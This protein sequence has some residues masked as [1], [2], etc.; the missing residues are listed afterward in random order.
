MPLRR[1]ATYHLIGEMEKDVD[2]IDIEEGDW[3]FESEAK[4]GNSDEDSDEDDE[5]SADDDEKSEEGEYKYNEGFEHLNRAI[6]GDAEVLSDD[7]ERG[8][9]K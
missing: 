5:D 2:K 6:Y 4:G 8:S 1:L 7:D 9:S 3:K